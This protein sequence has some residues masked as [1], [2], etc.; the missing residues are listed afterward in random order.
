MASVPRYRRRGLGGFVLGAIASDVEK[1]LA[2]SL[3]FVVG[4]A[5][6]P[7]LPAISGRESR[8]AIIHTCVTLAAP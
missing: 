1:E 2:R 3:E 6:V 7:F 4:D 8:E 5:K